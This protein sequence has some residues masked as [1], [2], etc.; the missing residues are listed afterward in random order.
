MAS[1]RT[2]KGTKNLLIDFSFMGI[3]CREQTA[4]PDTPANRKTLEKLLQK[5]EAEILL[6]TF[7]YANYFPNSSMV[8]KF[9]AITNRKLAVNS[10]G[11]L[12]TFEEFAQIW[13]EEMAISWR[14]S[15]A[16]TMD[17][18]VKNRLVPYFGKKEVDSITKADLSQFRATLGKVRREN[19]EPISA[20]YINRHIKTMQMII[21][22]A[23]DRYQFTAPDRMKPLKTKKTD[24]D[25]MTLPEVNLFLSKVPAEFR[26]YYIVRFFTGL[27]TAEIDGL[28]WRYIDFERGLILVRETVV[29]GRIEY[30]KTD[31]SQREVVMSAVVREAL[32][33]QQLET[34][35][36]TFVFGTKNDT[37]YSHRNITQRVWYPALDASGLRHRTPYQTRHTAAT[38][39]LAAGEN[40]EWIAR[41]MGH[42]TSE[43]LF[44]VYSRYV[45]NLTRQDGS[46]FENLLANYLKQ[47]AA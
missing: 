34:G 5:I 43:M 12:P 22:E 3:R 10:A 40:P 29:G 30:T 6:G 15:Y 17:I 47:G 39:W 1:I 46:A 33:A 38:L 11:R 35:G 19:G 44:K 16:K 20:V 27:R 2:R 37:P 31:G 7:V 41:Q 4:L 42:T 32:L 13:L 9:D 14:V 24:V 18:I 26:N 25:P 8:Q 21:R 23:A 36:K 45:P 28:K